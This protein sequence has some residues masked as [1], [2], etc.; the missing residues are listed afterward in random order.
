MVLLCVDDQLFMHFYHPVTAF[1]NNHLFKD[2]SKANR[3]GGHSVSLQG[4]IVFA[5]SPV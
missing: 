5:C 2:V 3:L 4:K 1:V